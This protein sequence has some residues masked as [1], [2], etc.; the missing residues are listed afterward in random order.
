MQKYYVMAIKQHLQGKC[1]TFTINA[2]ENFTN[3]F[4]PQF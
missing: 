1:L 3:Y 2:R 4:F